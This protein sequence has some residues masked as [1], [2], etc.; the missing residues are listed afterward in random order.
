M[1]LIANFEADGTEAS[2]GIEQGENQGKVTVYDVESW[3]QLGEDI[4]G[5]KPKDNFGSFMAFGGKNGKRLAIAAYTGEIGETSYARIYDWENESWNQ[6]HEEPVDEKK[7][8]NLP[9]LTVSFSKNGKIFALGSSGIDGTDYVLIKKYQRNPETGKREWT[10]RGQA[11]D[12]FGKSISLSNNGKKI[13]VAEEGYVRIFQYKNKFNHWNSISDRIQ[14]AENTS[15][16]E[17]DMI[18]LSG[19]GKTV[20]IGRNTSAKILK[21]E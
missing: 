19:D 5:D 8:E 11:L 18:S 13:A 16:G 9:K 3:E 10:Q 2:H 6:I 20:A 12:G 1:I 15:S 17:F 21:Y 14:G 4:W 7:D